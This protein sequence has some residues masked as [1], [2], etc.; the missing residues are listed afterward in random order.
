MKKL[1]TKVKNYFKNKKTKILW[2][3]G[4][5]TVESVLLINSISILLAT[6]SIATAIGLL[7]M[8]A[9]GTYALFS[10]LVENYKTA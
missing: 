4:F 9:Y 1:L 10:I 5:W 6:G 3:A 7:A 8:Q 2:I